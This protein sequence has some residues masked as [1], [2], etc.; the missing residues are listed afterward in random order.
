MKNGVFGYVMPC[1]L[2][3]GSEEMCCV[4]IQSIEVFN[5]NTEI[6]D[7]FEKLRMSF[8]TTRHCIQDDSGSV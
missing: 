6:S 4:Y 3:A 7:S 2:V 1:T 5:V 8:Q